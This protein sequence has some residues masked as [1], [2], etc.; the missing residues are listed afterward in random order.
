M[1]FA[2]FIHED[3]LLKMKVLGE[4]DVYVYSLANS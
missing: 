2:I 1:E 4:S 3:D